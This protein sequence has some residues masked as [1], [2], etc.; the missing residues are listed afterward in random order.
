MGDVSGLVFGVV[1]AA[2]LGLLAVAVGLLPVWTGSGLRVTVVLTRAWSGRF[3]GPP[4]PRRCP[5]VP[6]HTAQRRAT[7]RAEGSDPYMT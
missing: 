4:S 6:A 7:D 5:D 2:V 3:G 1:L